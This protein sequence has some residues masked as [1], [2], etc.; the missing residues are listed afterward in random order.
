M[1][2]AQPR[3]GPRRSIRLAPLLGSPYRIPYRNSIGWPVTGPCIYP[4]ARRAFQNNKSHPVFSS[5]RGHR[6]L[7]FDTG[8]INI[9]PSIAIR[10]SRIR[11]ARTSRAIAGCEIISIT[12][13]SP[14]ADMHKHNLIRLILNPLPLKIIHWF[15]HRYLACQWKVI[16]IVSRKYI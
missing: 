10:G 13:K 16:R 8:W 15:R 12:A 1:H 2:A 14:F 6:G 11:R 9:A 7:D 5:V 4:R 3:Y